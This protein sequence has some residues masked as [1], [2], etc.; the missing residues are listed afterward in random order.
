MSNLLCE[1]IL[2]KRTKNYSTRER[3]EGQKNEK[4]QETSMSVRLDIRFFVYFRFELF[5]LSNYYY[6]KRT[7]TMAIALTFSKSRFEFLLLGRL[8]MNRTGCLPE[9]LF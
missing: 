4:L 6:R 7:I 2:I 9:G 8:P 1:E 3:I 5:C